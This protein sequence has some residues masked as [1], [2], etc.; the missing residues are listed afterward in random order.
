MAKV[1]KG[2]LIIMWLLL[3]QPGVIYAQ[4]SLSKGEARFSRN[5]FEEAIPYYLEEIN[6]SGNIQIKEK[7]LSRLADC[8]R[9][10]GN[11]S[12]AEAMYKKLL[13]KNK[14]HPEYLLKY[15]LS[16]KASSK[17]KEAEDVFIKY[18]KLMPSNP[19]GA[20]YIESCILAQKWLDENIA[21]EARKPENVNSKYSEFAPVFYRDGFLFCSARPESK[22]K[23]VSLEPGSAQQKLDFYVVKDLNK[24]IV[25]PFQDGVLNTYLHE[26]PAAFSPSGDTIYF[27]TTVRGATGPKKKGGNYSVLNIWMSIYKEGI[28]SKPQSAGAFNSKFYSVG[29]PSVSADGKELYFMSDMP[30][31]YGATDIY[32]CAMQRDGSW[33]APANLGMGINTFGHE[34]FPFIAADNTLYFSSDAHPGMGKLDVFKSNFNGGE[35]ESPENLKPPVNSIGDDFAFVIHPETKN[36]LFSSDRFDSEGKDDIYA[37]SQ[38]T[39][40]LVFKGGKISF[41]HNTFFDGFRTKVTMAGGQAEAELFYNG[42][43]LEFQPQRG[44]EYLITVRKDGLLYN[45]ISV[46]V[47]DDFLISSELKPLKI[48]YYEGRSENENPS[49]Y[50][51]YPGNPVKAP[52]HEVL[53]R[54]E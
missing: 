35:W 30:G 34:L 4:K 8:Y 54:V 39:F 51:I 52:V 13:Q 7:A 22:R 24:A 49:H 3:F 47:L 11:F 44:Q 9:L 33:G 18:S 19:M 6:G 42:K 15:G 25:E 21:L 53:E 31:G 37:F 14:K 40:T 38:E 48:H 2:L 46:S 16:L 23:F 5:L 36:I 1:N 43:Y 20:V 41:L 32:K 29:H 28:W 27:T 17:Y 10:T 45:K 50:F 26:G 12:E